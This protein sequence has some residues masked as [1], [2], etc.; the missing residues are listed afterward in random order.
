[1]SAGSTRKALPFGRSTQFVLQPLNSMATQRRGRNLI[2]AV[3]KAHLAKGALD[4]R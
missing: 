3:D 4:G 2:K 1:M